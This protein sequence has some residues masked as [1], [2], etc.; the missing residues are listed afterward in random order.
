[1]RSRTSTVMPYRSTPAATSKMASSMTRMGM[2]PALADWHCS[3][4]RSRMTNNAAEAHV[5]RRRVHRLWMTRSRAVSTAVIRHAQV[6]SA[7][8]HLAR[9]S[10]VG[11]AGVIARLLVAT[12]RNPRDTAG[13]GDIGLIRPDAIGAAW[14]PDHGREG[15][16]LRGRTLRS[17]RRNSIMLCHRPSSSSGSSSSRLTKVPTQLGRPR[18]LRRQPIAVAP[19]RIDHRP[20]LTFA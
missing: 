11:R 4:R 10:D 13:L 8:K 5:A 12:S 2:S 15:R 16:V 18:L 17:P 9:N 14:D 6:R 1:M 3:T 7:L 19:S 20:S